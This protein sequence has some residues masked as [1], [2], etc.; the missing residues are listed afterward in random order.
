MVLYHSE[1]RNEFFHKNDSKNNILQSLQFSQEEGE[2]MINLA[3]ITSKELN[4]NCNQ[5]VIIAI[6][7]D[8][9]NEK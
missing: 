7:A 9:N 1:S 2:E 4:I 5:D 3:H 6:T 8:L